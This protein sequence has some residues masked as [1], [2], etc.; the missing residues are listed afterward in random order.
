LN[1]SNL[2][3]RN[4]VF[5]PKFRPF[6]LRFVL[7]GLLSMTI[8]VAAS[9]SVLAESPD[10]E[11][12]FRRMG[13]SRIEN[14]AGKSVAK[15]LDDWVEK[16]V[17]ETLRFEVIRLKKPLRLNG[18][19]DEIRARSR[20]RKLDLVLTGK[21]QRADRKVRLAL[22][23]FEGSSGK[24]FAV[25]YAM[26]DPSAKG[27]AGKEAVEDL[28]SKL[29]G[30]IPYGALVTEVREKNIHLNAG[31][32]SGIETGD[33]LAVVEILAV[34]RHPF[35]GEAIGFKTET[36][37]RLRV[38]EANERSSVAVVDQMQ[39]GK[40]IRIGSKIVFHPSK[41][42]LSRAEALKKEYFARESARPIKPAKRAAPEHGG[43]VPTESRVQFAVG[44]GL[45]ENFYRF[46]SDEFEF[47]R[48]TTAL[49]TVEVRGMAWMTRSL[50]I[51]FSFRQ[52]NMNFDEIDGS[53]I[54]V[55]ST[56]RWIDGGIAYRHRFR[57]DGRG[58]M[59]LAGAGYH[60]Y[61]FDPNKKDDTFFNQYTV[62]G[63][64]LGVGAD[65][66][67][68]GPVSLRAGMRVW[69]WLKNRES[70]VDSGNGSSGSGYQLQ[71]G[72]H[73]RV[74]R[75]LG[76]EAMYG[77]ERYHSDFTGTGTRGPSGVT[78]AKVTEIYNGFHIKL[79]G[80]F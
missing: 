80:T 45:A 69:P 2:W 38:I 32:L 55:D 39:P 53:P 65:V 67:V 52:G 24:P 59:V 63:P 54:N 78:H 4:S 33:A 51:G 77:L 73:V 48:R 57:S 58:P 60:Q 64:F 41:A 3:S 6:G 27:A 22:A 20:A 66:P 9:R 19:A 61:R 34:Q 15:G 79:T 26:Y 21:I 74:W 43:A 11:L 75:D 1:T 50:G 10:E 47:K 72:A 62:S 14:L 17:R 76:I 42:A 13:I 46:D 56:V 5:A 8:I 16:A 35:T 71:A 23:L 68:R 36:V 29:T 44:T 25:E 31:R 28:I 49:L 37:G 12:T 7:V 30:R 70:G 40:F 18:S